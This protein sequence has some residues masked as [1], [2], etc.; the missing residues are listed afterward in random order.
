MSLNFQIRKFN[1]DIIKHRCEIDSRKSPMIVVIG[2]KDTGK[3]FLVRDILANNISDDYEDLMDKPWFSK[4]I[5]Q[6]F[7]L[8]LSNSL[9]SS[10][11]CLS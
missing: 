11:L 1:M 5:G 10:S 2:K 6:T 9:Q 3:S 4:N 7:E 8:R